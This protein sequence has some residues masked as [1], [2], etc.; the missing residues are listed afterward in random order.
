MR[1]GRFLT[2]L[3]IL[4]LGLV[5]PA[6]AQRTRRPTTRPTPKP[7]PYKP[8]NTTTRTT[9][10]PIVAAA[11]QQVANQLYN[12]NQ[13]VD[14]MGPIAVGIENFDKEAKTNRRIKKELVDENERNKQKMVLAIRGMRQGLSKLETDFRTKPQLSKYLLKIQGISTL[15]AQSEDNAIAGRFVASKDPLR[16]VAQKLSDTMAVMP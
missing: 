9:V 12:V 4:L 13:F 3:S 11:K 10:S 2:I 8:I 1:T 16:Q 6:A 14:I 5:L 15:C 7:T